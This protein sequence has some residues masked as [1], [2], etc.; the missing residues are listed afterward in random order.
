MQETDRVLAA[1]RA[2]GK[3]LTNARKAI[4]G[5]VTTHDKPLS[6]LDMQALLT[7]KK[8]SV[9]A[10]TIYRELQFL[11]AEGI[12]KGVHFQDGV[13][14]YERTSLPHHHHLVCLSCDAV[15][16]VH[17]DRELSTIE[18]RIRKAH[19]FDVES[20]SLEFYG[21]CHNCR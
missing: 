21:R 17:M 18:T 3:R 14:R 7:R 8:L 20:H 1:L 4:V 11:E 2:S 13:Q 5:I 9:N 15:E 19:R 6:A 16:D 10:T 12:V